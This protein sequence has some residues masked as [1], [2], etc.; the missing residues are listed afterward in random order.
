MITV[1]EAAIKVDNVRTESL[2]TTNASGKHGLARTKAIKKYHAR[3]LNTPNASVANDGE[4]KQGKDKKEK[5]G[6]IGSTLVSDDTSLSSYDADCEEDKS[7]I[8]QRDTSSISQQ[9][10]S[11]TSKP[12]VRLIQVAPAKDTAQINTVDDSERSSYNIQ[13]E[14]KRPL[15]Q[16]IFGDS[17]GETDYDLSDPR[18]PYG[19]NTDVYALRQPDWSSVSTSSSSDPLY[20]VPCIEDFLPPKETQTIEADRRAVFRPTT[21]EVRAMNMIFR[22]PESPTPSSSKSKSA[23]SNSEGRLMKFLKRIQ[24]ILFPCCVKQDQIDD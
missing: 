13:A 9:D 17:W 10:K 16:E 22:R 20:R 8:C 14:A 18:T 3:Q 11:L 12:N 7:T 21:R 2:H 5:R 19:S 15:R 23:K 6:N 1:A 4:V 24:N